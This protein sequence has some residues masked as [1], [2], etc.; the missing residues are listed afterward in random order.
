MKKLDSLIA[1]FNNSITQRKVTFRVPNTS[2][3]YR[4]V[5]NFWRLNYLSMVV[6][7]DLYLTITHRLD[8]SGNTTIRN[9]RPLYNNIGRKF[10]SVKCGILEK[11]VRDR[12]GN[13]LLLVS[14]AADGLSWITEAYSNKVGGILLLQI[15][16]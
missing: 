7:D 13:T 2:L 12:S 8:N 11:M 3:N 10:V 16:F 14:G 4:V 9:I 5:K 15:Y 6:K 1:S